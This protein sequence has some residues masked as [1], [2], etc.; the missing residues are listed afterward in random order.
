M[1]ESNINDSQNIFHLPLALFI[2]FSACLSPEKEI[3][4]PASFSFTAG[5]PFIAT[6]LLEGTVCLGFNGTLN[7]M[8]SAAKRSVEQIKSTVLLLT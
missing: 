4:P 5:V 1:D 6:S 3:P 7:N 2:R 8:N